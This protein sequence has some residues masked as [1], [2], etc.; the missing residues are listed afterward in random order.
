MLI[1][2]S[3]HPSIPST[4]F[5]SYLISPPPAQPDSVVYLTI[6]DKSYPRK[7]AFSYLDEL[8]KEFERSYGTQVASRSLRPYAFVGFGA[9]HRAIDIMSENMRIS[10]KGIGPG[11]I[12]ERTVGRH[13][14]RELGRLGSCRSHLLMS[15]TETVNLFSMERLHQYSQP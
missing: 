2:S 4:S 1:E 13:L 9:Y 6:T 3:I 10:I 11:A 14:E 15:C 7:L 12:T 5:N 8:S